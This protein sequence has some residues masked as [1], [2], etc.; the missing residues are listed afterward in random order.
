MLILNCGGTFNKR[1]NKISG[2]LEVPFDNEAIEQILSSVDFEYTLA[3]VIY[4]DSLE[5]DLNDRKMLANIIMES[6]EDTFIIVHG[7]DTIS[8]TAEFLDEVFEDRK[9]IL[10]GSMKPF[11]I[12]NIEA[13]LNLGM[14]LGFANSVVDN[15]VYICMSGFIK[16]WDELEK[17]RKS[18]KF[19]IVE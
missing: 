12:D 11:E 15:G 9:I 18:G 19:E 13:T 14:S 6:T 17:N 10:T 7:T 16:P 2:D 5:M 1:Y 4:K 3:G 8:I